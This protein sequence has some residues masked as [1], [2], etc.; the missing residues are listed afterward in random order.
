LEDYRRRRHQHL[1]DTVNPWPFEVSYRGTVFDI[2]QIP[3][4]PEVFRVRLRNLS[5]RT[6]YF[7]VFYRIPDK[8]LMKV[9]PDYL[10]ALPKQTQLAKGMYVVVPPLS[11][12]DV[13][14]RLFRT[15]SLVKE[16]PNRYELVLKEF[17]HR[18]EQALFRWPEELKVEPTIDPFDSIW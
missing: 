7:D 4:M 13:R 15:D 11:W 12:L 2:P 17:Y 18:E 1:L 10:I 3:D 9:Y 16:R 5:T 8:P 6:A 14:T